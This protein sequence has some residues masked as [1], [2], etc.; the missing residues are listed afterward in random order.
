MSLILAVFT[1]L[2]KFVETWGQSCSRE[3]DQQG[4]HHLGWVYGLA[5]KHRGSIPVRCTNAR[6]SLPLMSFPSS[7]ETLV[8]FLSRE[9]SREQLSKYWPW[10]RSQWGF[11][12]TEIPNRVSDEQRGEHRAFPWVKGSCSTPWGQEGKNSFSAMNS[13]LVALSGKGMDRA[14]C[15]YSLI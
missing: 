6:H 2:S 12:V 14:P 3:A 11:P 15:P 10:L 1:S 5:P 9:H 4:H 7:P 13:F 8:I